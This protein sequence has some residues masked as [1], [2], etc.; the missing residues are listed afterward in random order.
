M[1][2][3]RRPRL[4]EREVRNEPR[5]STQQQS[6]PQPRPKVNPTLR[7]L[8]MI[9][10]GWLM[11]VIAALVGGEMLGIQEVAGGVKTFA[12]TSAGIVGTFTL[13][14]LTVFDAS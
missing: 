13:I 12:L 1:A 6:L 7:G 14:V 9:G 10:V 4:P 8:A 11:V 5:T 3:D 2:T